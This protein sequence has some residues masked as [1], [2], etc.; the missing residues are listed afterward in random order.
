MFERFW[1]TGLS[2]II[3]SYCVS[4]IIHFKV[5]VIILAL[6]KCNL[7]GWKGNIHNEWKT[8]SVAIRMMIVS[9][10]SI[11]SW[12][13]IIINRPNMEMEKSVMLLNDPW[14]DLLLQCNSI[15]HIS[16]LSG[17]QRDDFHQFCCTH[18][19]CWVELTTGIGLINL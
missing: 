14:G 10:L 13:L 8:M 12:F 3:K 16:C 5:I 2:K 17:G 9:L 18:P 1:I 7:T 6:Y 11:F 15:G 4:K 19:C